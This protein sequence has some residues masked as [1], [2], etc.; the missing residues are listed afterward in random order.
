M[1]TFVCCLYICVLDI[2]VTLYVS[3]FLHIPLYDA[4]I[5][6][7]LISTPYISV[8]CLY[9]CVLVF[10]FTQY[11]SLFLCIHLYVTC[12]LVSLI[13]QLFCTSLFSVYTC[14]SVSLI[15][16]GYSIYLCSLYTPVF[17]LNIFV[18]DISFHFYISLFFCIPLYI[19]CISVSLISAL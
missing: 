17:C 11:I 9:I 5:S 15:F 3:V 13:S 19:A 4:F 14:I 1:Y 16:L 10:F 18:L 8:L 6:V 2:S 12:I 7:S